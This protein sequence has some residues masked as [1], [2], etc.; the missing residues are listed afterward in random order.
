MSEVPKEGYFPVKSQSM[1][2]SDGAELIFAQDEMKLIK[3]ESHWTAESLLAQEGIFFLKDILELLELDGVKVIKHARDMEKDGQ[4]PW[5]VM[6]MRKVWN[7]WAIR[8]TVFA[9]YYKEHLKSAVRNVRDHWDANMLLKQEGLFLLT[10]V[11]RLLPFTAYQI[12]Y[13]AKKNPN[14]KEEYGI[15]KD[16]ELKRYLVD[17]GIFSGW[18]KQLW[19]R[20]QGNPNRT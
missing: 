19:A 7:H 3:V 5:E 9:P 4:N 11:C 2:K 13:Q 10:D 16:D 20:H 18:I 17:M 8:M 1:E 15:W 6:G 12:R 14:A